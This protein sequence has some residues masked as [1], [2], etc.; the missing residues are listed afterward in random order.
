[1]GD[2]QKKI[3]GEMTRITAEAGLDPVVH[4]DYPNTGG[5]YVQA[6][7]ETVLTVRFNFQHDY[8][9]LYYTGPAMEAW[10][11]KAWKDGPGARWD[12]HQKAIAAHMVKYAGAGELAQ[13]V[14]MFTVMLSCAAPPRPAP[15]GD[16]EW[17]SMEDAFADGL[18]KGRGEAV[19]EYLAGL[20][21]TFN[22]WGDGWNGGDLVQY[23]TEEMTRLG[24][25]VKTGLPGHADAGLD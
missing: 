2:M 22:G 10:K 17:N 1:M 21:T 20:A 5:L 24:V 15:A 18:A 8:C 14:G 12:P 3:L 4:H 19:R 11:A 6:G 9:T 16:R 25:D 13:Q 7:L 23:L